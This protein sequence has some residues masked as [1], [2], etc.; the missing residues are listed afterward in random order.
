M[1][2]RVE[3]RY[4]SS[5]TIIIEMGYDKA[6]KKRNRIV[7]SVEVD[8][9]DEATDLMIDM[10]YEIRHKKYVSP[11]TMTLSQY[12]DKWLAFRKT[13]LAPKTYHSYFSEIERHVKP[14]IGN[15]PL[16][17]VEAIHL[18]EYYLKMETEGRIKP[19]DKKGSKKKDASDEVPR[20]KK[21]L[22]PGLSQRTINYHH[23]ILSA[24]LKQAVKW[25]MIPYNPA[26]YVDTPTYEKKEMNFMRKGELAPFLEKIK[27]HADYAV[28][29]TAVMTGMR[30][31]EVL[32]LRW[33]DVDFDHGMINVRQQ[34][35]YVPGKSFF[36][37]S[38]KSA[39]SVRAIPMQL[40]LSK[41][42][43]DVK[44]AQ[45]EYRRVEEEKLRTKQN[46]EITEADLKAIYDD[47]G[48]V[49]CQINGK[50]LDGSKVTNRFKELVIEFG[51][52][53]LR[54][55]DL[56][57]TFAALAIAAGIAMEKLQKFMGHEKIT[58][59]IDMYG[60]IP[61]DTLTEEMKKLSQYLGFETLAK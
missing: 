18:Q 50:P 57:H 21:E 36:F 26:Q 28:I 38:P 61:A 20:D 51:R 13:K 45:D 27:G 39:K 9:E 23:R 52:P 59:T 16:Q 53:E 17:E 44:K 41:M 8:T 43:K 35:Q 1:K 3:K 29:Y 4:E 30:Q 54:F 6:T 34:L 40:P 2:G 5:W 56:R 60:H 10:M 32:G 11:S 48:L 7:K 47:Q 25:K 12:L 24:A 42:L 37:K 22:P 33:Y 15:I 19:E 14:A 49:L 31:G 58:T 55:H 46:G